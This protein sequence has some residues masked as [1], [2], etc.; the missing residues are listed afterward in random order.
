MVCDMLHPKELSAPTIHWSSRVY[1]TK[2]FAYAVRLASGPYNEYLRPVESF[3]LLPD[4]CV[5]LLSE[6]EADAMQELACEFRLKGSASSSQSPQLMKLCYAQQHH[7][8]G[9]ISPFPSLSLSLSHCPA[10]LPPVSVDV[11]VSLGLLNGDTSF[12]EDQVAILRTFMTGKR[13]S[14]EELVGMR[15]KQSLLPRSELDKVI[16][17][18]L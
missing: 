7:L 3:L 16:N 14:A 5:V 15:G 18:M 13:E 9:C 4:G 10:A 17:G 12:G 8:S 1:C 11:L 6:R 2:N